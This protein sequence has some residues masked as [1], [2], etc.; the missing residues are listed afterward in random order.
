MPFLR[1]ESKKEGE[2]AFLKTRTNAGGHVVLCDFTEEGEGEIGNNQ[3]ERGAE[4][5]A[6]DKKR[7]MRD[8]SPQLA[9]HAGRKMVENKAANTCAAV[10]SGKRVEK[11]SAFPV[12]AMG[13]G[14]RSGYKIQTSDQ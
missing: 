4:R 10:K 7:E 1:I 8:L 13:E 12:D 14:G 2:F 5:F 9:K 11:I 6:K 3:R